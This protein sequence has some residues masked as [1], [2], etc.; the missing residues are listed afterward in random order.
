VH[1]LAF[2]FSV[3]PLG[4]VESLILACLG[5]LGGIAVAHGVVAW[6]HTK[7]NIVF[8]T[9]LPIGVPFQM[10][11]R[12]LVVCIAL[13]A[14][15]ALL[16]GL[17]PALQSTRGDLVNGLKS[18]DVDLPGRKRL[19]GR[20]ALVVAQVS[21]SLMLLTACFLMARSFQHSLL[22]GTGFSKDHLLISSFDPRLEQYNAAQTKQFYKLLTERV[23][24]TPGVQGA[25]LSHSIRTA[26]H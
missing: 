14:M 5:G 8:M 1:T 2:G 20:S 24:E 21:T 12:V 25:A 3:K 22:G 17:A 13:S 16:C 10:D 6:F 7:Q 9:D 18:A 23:R 26:G 11:N 4:R 15:C 19:W